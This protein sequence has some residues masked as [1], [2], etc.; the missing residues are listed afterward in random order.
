MGEGLRRNMSVFI[1]KQEIEK[2]KENVIDEETGMTELDLFE[3]NHC[4]EDWRIA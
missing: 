2:M 3:W 1:S 4:N